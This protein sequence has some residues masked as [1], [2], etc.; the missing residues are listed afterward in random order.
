MLE[1]AKVGALQLT[2]G[3]KAQCGQAGGTKVGYSEGEEEA[4]AG[5]V[6]ALGWGEC[7][8]ATGGCCFLVSIISPKFPS[9]YPP[10]A[11]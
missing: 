7:C 2:Y 3:T 11:C 5:A 9:P 1:W 8:L 4:V 10:F 6:L